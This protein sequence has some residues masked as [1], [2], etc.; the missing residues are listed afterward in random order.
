MTGR[1]SV[2]MPTTAQTASGLF[3]L[4]LPSIPSCCTMTR[5]LGSRNVE[6]LPTNLA[7]AHLGISQR[8]LRKIRSGLKLGKHYRLISVRGAIRPTYQ[9]NPAR[10]AEYLQ[11]PLE[12]R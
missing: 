12:K 4:A 1:L 9:W 7:A 11:I 2:W 3:W 6:W 8:Q 5:P 10:I